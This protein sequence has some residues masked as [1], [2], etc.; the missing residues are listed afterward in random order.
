MRCRVLTLRRRDRAAPRPSTPTPT[1][2]LTTACSSSTRRHPRAAALDQLRSPRSGDSAPRLHVR[3]P[4]PRV[5]CRQL[6]RD[7]DGD[8]SL[9]GRLLVAVERARPVRSDPANGSTRASPGRGRL[10]DTHRPGDGGR[11]AASANDFRCGDRTAPSLRPDVSAPR[12]PLDAIESLLET[13]VDRGDVVVDGGSD[14]LDDVYAAAARRQRDVDALDPGV[15][16]LVNPHEYHV[17]ITTAVRDEKRRL[18][19]ALR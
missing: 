14:G 3:R 9:D 11:A 19:E 15:R 7:H 4:P 6:P 8:P 2:I 18:L 17:S 12:R 5:R 13:I 10:Y 1:S 16:R